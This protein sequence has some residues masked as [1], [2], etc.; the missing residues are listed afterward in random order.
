MYKF[1]IQRLYKSKFCM[2]MNVQNMYIK[3]LHIYKKVQTVQNFCIYKQCT[4]Y[5]KHIQLA[6]TTF[7]C[8]LYIQNNVQTIQNLYN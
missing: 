6:E 2:I 1:C 7:I 8:F 5:T 3:F 4:K